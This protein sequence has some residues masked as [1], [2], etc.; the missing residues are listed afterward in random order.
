[1]LAQR[2]HRGHEFEIPDPGAGELA[3]EPTVDQHADD[4]N[5]ALE[6]RAV[7]GPE[8]VT[9]GGEP[10]DEQTHAA[11]INEQLTMAEADTNDTE[12][13]ELPPIYVG[14]HVSDRDDEDRATM[15]VVGLA[16]A[17]A[18]EYE[19]GGQTIAE[20][21]PDYPSDADVIEVVY[22]QR[23]DVDV[24]DSQT[25]AFPRERLELVASI[26]DLEGDAEVSE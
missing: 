7:A 14:D 5:P 24:R 25:Y 17:D 12:A 1:M 15:L 10:T 6:A 16:V 23:T 18:S 4:V 8:I 22:P 11:R 2:D 21:N 20:Y 13:E 3:D 26:H 19:V 9:D